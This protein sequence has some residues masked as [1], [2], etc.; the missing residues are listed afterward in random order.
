MLG[1]VDES[2]FC[3]VSLYQRFWSVISFHKLCGFSSCLNILCIL[4]IT[5][6]AW[7]K[8]WRLF[9]VCKLYMSD[10][11]LLMSTFFC[12]LSKYDCWEAKVM[13]LSCLRSHIVSA[14]FQQQ[15]YKSS[16][17]HLHLVSFMAHR[18]ASGNIC[19]VLQCTV[20]AII[21][22]LLYI[23]DIKSLTSK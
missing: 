13:V 8:E 14:R 23:I 20:S 1:L 9:W 2:M 11:A 5:W 3:L 17:D 21:C 12:L 10:L 19:A 15:F 6:L 18:E 4:S 22:F 7:K 16:L